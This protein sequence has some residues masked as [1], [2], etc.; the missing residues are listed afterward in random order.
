MGACW[1]GSTGLLYVCTLSNGASF[2]P[3]GQMLRDCLE[4]NCRTYVLACL[5]PGYDTLGETK[6]V[7]VYVQVVRSNGLLFRC[8]RL[9]SM[10]LLKPSTFLVHI[11]AA[12]E[13]RELLRSS[14]RTAPTRW[15]WQTESK[16]R[17]AEQQR[18]PV[19]MVLLPS[20]V[21]VSFW[22]TVKLCHLLQLGRLRAA[23]TSATG[24]GLRP[25]GE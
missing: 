22:R 14:W 24:Q 25:N 16:T 12:C 23:R 10:S 8:C 2:L 20:H 5:N 18:Y 21:R 3:R 15:L 4:G 17:E 9:T 1:A 13:C 7:L 11:L 6:N 19:G